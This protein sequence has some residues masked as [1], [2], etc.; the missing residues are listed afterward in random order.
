[1]KIFVPVILLLLINT[2]LF[3]QEA[4][5]KFSIRFGVGKSL[6]G[7]GDILTTTFENELNYNLNE[8]FTTALSLNYGRSSSDEY[9][10]AVFTQGNL[11]IYLSPFRNT[12]RNDFRIGAGLTY[13]KIR[14][15]VIMR[16]MTDRWGNVLW[17]DYRVETRRSFG[18]NIILENTY[19]IRPRFLLGLKLFTQPYDNGDINTGILL[20]VGYKL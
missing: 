9:D 20:K 3:A 10:I 2:K 16:T 18:Y 17:S 15:G 5:S 11:N 19:A 1:M 13:Y 12:R 14:D 7:S 6:L 4:Q 8:Y